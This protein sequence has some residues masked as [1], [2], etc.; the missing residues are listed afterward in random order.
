ME[1]I[2]QRDSLN[3]MQGIWI[4]YFFNEKVATKSNFLNGREINYYIDFLWNQNFVLAKDFF[5]HRIF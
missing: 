3:R 4:H 5:Y 1:K 2:N